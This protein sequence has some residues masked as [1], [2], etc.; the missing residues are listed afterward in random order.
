MI[1]IGIAGEFHG[2]CGLFCVPEH[3][4]FDDA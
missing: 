2:L 1:F 3:A 4:F